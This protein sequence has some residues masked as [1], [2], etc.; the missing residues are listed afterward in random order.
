[1]NLGF[2]SFL[3]IV[4]YQYALGNRRRVRG[5]PRRVLDSRRAH[6]GTAN[7][8]PQRDAGNPAKLHLHIPQYRPLLSADRLLR[9]GYLLLQCLCRRGIVANWWKNGFV[10]TLF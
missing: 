1:M 6:G 3:R 5:R 4:A 10:V 9:V 8:R 2:R 7:K